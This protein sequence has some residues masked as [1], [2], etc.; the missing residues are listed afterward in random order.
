MA[1]TE[2]GAPGIPSG[3]I[4]SMKISV[5]VPDPDVAYLDAYAEANDL[6]S[7]SAAVH[8]AVDA[9]RHVGLAVAYEDA[10]DEWDASGDRTVWDTASSDGL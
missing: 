3:S 6:G 4:E 1:R 8:H 7:R 5:S 2:R 9:L 10:W